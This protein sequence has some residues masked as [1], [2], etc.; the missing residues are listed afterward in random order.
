MQN[1]LEKIISYKREEI[2]TRKKES[3]ILLLEK[4][5]GFKREIFSMKKFIDG[6]RKKRDHR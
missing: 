5:P 6:S 1:I 3:P 4:Q 2:E